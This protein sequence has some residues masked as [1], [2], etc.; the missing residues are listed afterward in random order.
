AVL[1]IRNGATV[2]TI[3]DAYLLSYQFNGTTQYLVQEV[4]GG[5]A[6]NEYRIP[7]L[8]APVGGVVD[9][10]IS[11]L[12]RLDRTTLSAAEAAA[13]TRSGVPTLVGRTFPV[14]V[15]PP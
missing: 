3:F 1:S 2:L 7:T 9:I 6:R 8:P 11:V 10:D 14:P 15:A 12:P 4:H 5:L 13:I